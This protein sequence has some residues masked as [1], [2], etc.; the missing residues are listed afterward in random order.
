MFRAFL[1]IIAVLLTY[2]KDW[3][4][5]TRQNEVR[6]V[7]LADNGTLWAAF[8]WG[9][10][11]RLANKTENNYMP[12]S[13]NLE[14]ADFV[15][16][17]DLPS[18]DIIAVS[19][20]GSLIRKNKNSKNFETISN[21]FAE[22]KRELLPGLGKRA[23]NIL[24]LP[25]KGALAFF[26]YEQ[27][28]SIITLSQI[29]TNSLESFLVKRVSVKGDS[30]WIEFDRAIWKRKIDWN[31]ISEDRF[32]ADPNSWKKADKIPEEKAKASYVPT[33]SDFPLETVRVISVLSGIG[34][35]AWGNDDFNYF[36]RMQNDKWGE[37]FLSDA[38][39]FGQ[40]HKNWPAKSLAMQ[41]NGSF[42]VGFWGAGLVTFD[43]NFPVAGSTGWFHSTNSNNTCPTAYKDG[44]V[45]GWTIV[46][47][48]SAIPDFSGF[49]FSFFSGGNY[50]FGFVDS[51]LKAKCFKPTKA[52][53]AIATSIVAKKSETGEWEIYIAWRSSISSKEGGVDFYKAVPSK[54]SEN[55]SP[56]WQNAWTLPFGSPIEFAFDSD[57]ILW[58]ISNS[59][60]FY[61][62]QNEWKEPSYIRGFDGGF[63][64]ALK[65][66][67]QNGLWIGTQ[68]NGAYLLSKI[69]NSL[70]SLTA[71]HF[72]TR[73]GLLSEMVYDIAI[74][75]IKGK[76]YFAHDLGLS[77]YSTP[78]VR[79]A[80]NYMQDDAPKSIAYP[81]PFRP[82]LHSAVTIDY[83][84]DKSVLYIFDSSG[85]RVRFFNSDEL[86]G[87]AVAWDGKNEEGK[88]VAPGIYHYM[89]KDGKKTAKGKIMVER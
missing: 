8:A 39:K 35:L 3:T 19:R 31:K 50:G 64:S 52:S 41:S 38:G 60:I 30:L 44:D 16:I 84:S 33:Q 4:H 69:N 36:S 65:T 66:D 83:I 14:V 11:E 17:F 58:A 82:K 40:D 22:K 27:K 75:T 79:G 9:L 61:L 77:V 47:G 20:N 80:S 15:Q 59:K 6:D 72:K 74:D 24:I 28:Y 12:G 45:G 53:S 34:A 86:R 89:A 85:K 32:L 25:F 5:Y 87:G 18:G 54:N 62:F 43:A 73:N 42:A 29:G 70:D 76:V 78:I 46:Y 71:K 1:L 13:N 81:N 48:V 51:N 7:V 68:G 55:F 26:D 49:L 56:I 23:N 2:A 21:S 63:I 37:V 67:A 57:G 88:L 10:Q